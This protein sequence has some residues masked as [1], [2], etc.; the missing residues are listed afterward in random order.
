MYLLNINRLHTN[1]HKTHWGWDTR[2]NHPHKFCHLTTHCEQYWNSYFPRTIP[3]WN[4][5]PEPVVSASQRTLPHLS[6]L[7]CALP[8]K[9][10]VITSLP[11]TPTRRYTRYR[12]QDKYWPRS[13]LWP[14]FCRQ[15]FNLH[16]LQWKL[17]CFDS[18]FTEICSQGYT[19]C[20]SSI[21]SDNSLVPNRRQA[22]IWTSDVLFPDAYIH[23]SASMSYNSHTIFEHTRRQQN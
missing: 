5:L 12:G 10:C 4:L 3:E 15:H 2:S 17:L 11:P 7:A 16:F 13:R 23:H 21:H 9:C 20:Y 8:H 19:S 22:I 18:N 1:L 14:T 6:W